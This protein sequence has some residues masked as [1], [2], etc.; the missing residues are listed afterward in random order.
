MSPTRQDIIQAIESLPNEALPELTSFVEQ[1]HLRTEP[2]HL[3]KTSSLSSL[4]ALAGLGASGQ[5]DISETEEGILATEIDPLRGWT[6][7]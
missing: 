2:T 3:P 1:L 4:L 6:L 5:T 7:K